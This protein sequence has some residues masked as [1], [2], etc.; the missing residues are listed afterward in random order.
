MHV[1]QKHPS[2][3][4]LATVPPDV[5]IFKSLLVIYLQRAW[6]QVSAI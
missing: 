6:G 2:G 4:N 1:F 3:S 5:G